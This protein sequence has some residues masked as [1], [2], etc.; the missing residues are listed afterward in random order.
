MLTQVLPQIL[1]KNEQQLL[2]PKRP[3]EIWQHH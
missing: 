3:K 1:F 2:R